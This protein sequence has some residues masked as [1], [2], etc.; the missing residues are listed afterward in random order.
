MPRA[1]IQVSDKLKAMMPKERWEAVITEAIG[2]ID[3]TARPD[4]LVLAVFV[5]PF[6][7]LL[8]DAR[9]EE[10]RMVPIEEFLPTLFSSNQS[11]QAAYDDWWNSDLRLMAI[12]FPDW[13]ELPL[14]DS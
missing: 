9:K 8:I 6:S 13:F 3:E 11:I 12:P 7:V 10:G 4:D 1:I 2:F 14:G 5:K